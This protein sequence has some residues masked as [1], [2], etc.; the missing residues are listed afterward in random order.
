MVLPTPVNIDDPVAE[1]VGTTGLIL[2]MIAVI[3]FA[4]CLA[5]LGMSSATLG[6][7]AGVVAVCSFTASLW[8]LMADGRRAA[9]AEAVA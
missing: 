3:A 8:I 1:A 2:N 5:G 6:V 9:D 7:A 4:L